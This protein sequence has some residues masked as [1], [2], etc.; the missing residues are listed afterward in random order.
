M[1]DH[2]SRVTSRESLLA[3]I[4]HH[5]HVRLSFSLFHNLHN[6]RFTIPVGQASAC[7]ILISARSQ[8]QTGSSLSYSCVP[9]PGTDRYS[10]GCEK[11]RLRHSRWGL[12]RLESG[13]T[14]SA[15]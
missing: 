11:W 3:R 7:L 5:N 14:S 12:Q 9:H 4:S 10:F 1:R 8:R 15:I 13:L 2:E 6:K